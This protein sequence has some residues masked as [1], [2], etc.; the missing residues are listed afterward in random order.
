MKCGGLKGIFVEQ[1]IFDRMN[2]KIAFYSSNE[3]GL[4]TESKNQ[5]LHYILG[6]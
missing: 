4:S 2:R 3:H 1:K 6:S 5:L